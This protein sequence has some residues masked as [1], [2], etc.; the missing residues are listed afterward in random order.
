MVGVELVADRATKQPF[1]LALRVGPRVMRLALAEGL[2]LR[3]LPQGNT[4]AFSPPLPI[5]EEEIGVIVERFGRA[6]DAAMGQLTAEG[7]WRLH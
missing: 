4:M 7:I 1:D 5:T 2:I 3:A 6:L